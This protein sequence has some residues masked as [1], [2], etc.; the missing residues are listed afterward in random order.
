MKFVKL[1]GFEESYEISENGVVRSVERIVDSYCE[2]NGRTKNTFK[3]VIRKPILNRKGYYIFQ[4]RKNN[5]YVSKELHRLLAETFIDNPNN[6]RCVNHID[7]NKINNSLNNLEW[8]SHS[9]N[10]LH[11]Y[12]TGLRGD[13]QRRNGSKVPHR[14]IRYIKVLCDL[15]LS[16]KR[17]SETILIGKTTIHDIVNGKV[18]KSQSEEIQGLKFNK[19]TDYTIEVP[20]NVLKEISDIWSEFNKTIPC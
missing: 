14:L 12:K 4:L 16:S 10:L 11:A 1:K 19:K 7:G 18:Y 9:E 17:I 5:K 8:V 15:G 13:G 3:S 2:L 20:K 6:L